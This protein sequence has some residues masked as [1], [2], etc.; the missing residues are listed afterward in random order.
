MSSIVSRWPIASRATLAHSDIDEDGRVTIEAV[1]RIFA[2]VRDAYFLESP[3]VDGAAASAM[4]TSLRQSE[5]FDRVET[6]VTAAVGVTE[7]FPESFTMALRIRP[8]SGSGA[9]D[10]RA[11][12]TI[13]EPVTDALRDELIAREHAARFTL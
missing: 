1:E 10:A 3:T 2:G 13:G 8:H 11:T 6:P 5:P 7:I 9:V 4:L 12:V